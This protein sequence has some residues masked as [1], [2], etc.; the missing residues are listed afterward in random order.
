MLEYENSGGGWVTI[1]PHHV[2]MLKSAAVTTYT[3]IWLVGTDTSGPPSISV[4]GFR[5]DVMVD[6][7]GALGLGPDY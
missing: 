1:N 4:K 6:I 7:E 5:E 3:L 2:V